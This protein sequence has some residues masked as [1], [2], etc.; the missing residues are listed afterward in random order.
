MMLKDYKASEGTRRP[1]LT[2]AAVFSARHALYPI[3]T[4]QIE[5]SRVGTESRLRQNPGW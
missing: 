4:I 1:F 3:P 2:I 5:L